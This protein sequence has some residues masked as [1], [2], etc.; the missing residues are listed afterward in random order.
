V[1]AKGEGEGEGWMGSLQLIDANYDTENGSAMRSCC[2]AQGTLSGLLGG[3]RMEENIK[4]G[5]HIYVR[6]GHFAVQ[7]KLAQHCKSTIP[8]KIRHL[9]ASL[10]LNT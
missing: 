4:T 3:T 9:Y 2:T 5:M 1:V 6:Q 8:K 7:Q 10:W